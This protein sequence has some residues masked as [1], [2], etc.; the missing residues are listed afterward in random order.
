[1]AM[2]HPDEYV[3]YNGF[4][5]GVDGAQGLFKLDYW[6]NSYAEAVHG[7]RDY[8]HAN[9]APISWTTI[10]R[11]GVRA[12]GSAGYYFPTNFIFTTIASNADFFI[13]FT[14]DDCDKSLPGS[15]SIGSS[16][17]ARCCRWCSTAARSSPARAGPAVAGAP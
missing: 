9:T 14:K 4:V 17:W 12:A 3:Y 5:G 2:L 16:A 10:H 6:A 11:R 13:A 1:M 8:L 15:G 7:L